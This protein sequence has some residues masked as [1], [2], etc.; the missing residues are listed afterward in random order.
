MKHVMMGQA[1]EEEKGSEKKPSVKAATVLINLNGT[2]V[3]SLVH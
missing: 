1:T 2:I 3:V